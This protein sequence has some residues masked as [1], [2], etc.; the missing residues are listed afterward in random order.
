[1]AGGFF[2]PNIRKGK[3]IKFIPA[4]ML[5]EI[6]IILILFYWILSMLG[7]SM[8]NHPLFMMYPLL[9]TILAIIPV[10]GQRLLM[11]LINLA[12]SPLT[13]K[14]DYPVEGEVKYD[15]VIRLNNVQIGI[16]SPTFTIKDKTV[17]DIV[18]NAVID[19]YDNNGYLIESQEV[20]TQIVNYNIKSKKADF[21]IENINNIT[22]Q[23]TLPGHYKK[24]YSNKKDE[25]KSNQTKGE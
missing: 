13:N 16:N 14:L 3:Y 12:I 22:L 19:V 5:G 24:V 10:K 6:L 23:I 1:M 2:L 15:Q 8:M 21:Y 20:P 9:V 4:R 17:I 11:L 18:Q 25:Q 7:I